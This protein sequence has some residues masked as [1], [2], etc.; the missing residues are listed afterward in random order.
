MLRLCAGYCFNRLYSEEELKVLLDA[1]M[2]KP[3]NLDRCDLHVDSV[4]HS[5]YIFLLRLS[6]VC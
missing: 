1:F 6:F 3:I 4:M 5:V 2:R